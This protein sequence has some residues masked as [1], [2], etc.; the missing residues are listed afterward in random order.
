MRV[1]IVEDDLLF[2]R[3]VTTR[4]EK[5]GHTVTGVDN[6]DEAIRRILKDPYR[7]VIIDSEIGGMGAAELTRKIRDAQR[8]R[9][10]Y[11]MLYAEEVDKEQLVRL[12]EA[13]ADEYLVKPFNPMELRLRLV[14]AKRLLNLEDELREGGGTDAVTG[15][16]SLTSFVQ[17]MNIVLSEAKRS[18]TVGALMFVRVPEYKEIFE[19]DGYIPAQTMMSEIARVLGRTV[20]TSDMIGRIDDDLFCCLLQNTFWDKCKPL[21]EKFKERIENSVV[22]VNEIEIRPK[23]TIDTTNFPAG[24]MGVTDLIEH[25]ER[26][27]L[28]A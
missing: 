5:W 1:L 8:S 2:S 14:S 28:E 23:I 15:L 11:I 20:R 19:R 26:I 7:V 12:L 10:I 13:G 25:G 3:L 4:L 17:F 24:D 22:Y 21:A 18:N 16:V 27:P 6:A 9:Y